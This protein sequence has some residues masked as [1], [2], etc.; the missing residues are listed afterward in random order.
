MCA[1]VEGVLARFVSRLI[2]VQPGVRTLEIGRAI[3]PL[4]RW[5]T[6][7]VKK[8]T[9]QLIALPPGPPLVCEGIDTETPVR[10][11]QEIWPDEESYDLVL[12]FNGI[13]WLP[14]SA[15]DSVLPKLL[16]ALA[17]GGQLVIADLFLPFSSWPLQ[18]DWLT[19]GGTNWLKVADVLS[20]LRQEGCQPVP[21][22]IPGSP[23]QFI[24]TAKPGVDPNVYSI[25]EGSI[26]CLK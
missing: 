15:A 26:R 18:L 25:G 1:G 6:T 23:F 8:V 4:S 14:P 9:T 11:W 21:S 20:R 7:N 13:H 10:G 22:T 2:R 5:L 3:G 17:P 16:K 24:S 12:V 19:H